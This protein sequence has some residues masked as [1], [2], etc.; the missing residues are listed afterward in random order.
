MKSHH[1][2]GRL[3]LVWL[4]LQVIPHLDAADDQHFSVQL[5]LAGRLR[6]EP[7][8]SGGNPARLQRAPKGPRQSPGGGRHDVVQ[9]GGMR[10]M[11]LGVHAVV[12]GH[13]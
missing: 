8:L 13:L 11:D 2:L 5:D 7:A 4:K 9:R 12:L 1:P 10:R 6:T 3:A